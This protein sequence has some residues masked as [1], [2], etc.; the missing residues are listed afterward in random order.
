MLLLLTLKKSHQQIK[1][2]LKMKE[3]KYVLLLLREFLLFGIRYY[4]PLA[5]I[6]NIYERLDAWLQSYLRLEKALKIH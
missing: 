3:C 1:F 6:N 4:E 2:Y 5:E